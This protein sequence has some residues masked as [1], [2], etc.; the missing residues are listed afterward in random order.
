MNQMNQSAFFTTHPLPVFEHLSSDS[1][2]KLEA[3]LINGNTSF[4]QKRVLEFFKMLDW[5][6]VEEAVQDRFLQKLS[7]DLSR[8]LHREIRDYH[9]N[10]VS[11]RAVSAEKREQYKLRII[12]YF[13]AKIPSADKALLESLR[14]YELDLTGRDVNWR[15]HFTLDSFKKIDAFVQASHAERQVLF[16]RFKKDVATY[17]QNYDKIHQAQAA[18]ACEHVFSFDDWCDMMGDE[19]PRASRSQKQKQPT[20]PAPQNPVYQ[21]HQVLEVAFGSSPETVKKQ[22]RKLTLQ[23]HPDLPNGS[24]EKMKTLVGAYQE[25]QRYWQASHL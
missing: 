5:V 15:Y 21:A 16:E 4:R 18:G 17:K 25:L 12:E 14:D 22:F 7:P 13:R 11:N 24:E 20:Q 1:K 6:S 8:Q 3:Y 19:A 2:R 10:K 9:M 23:H